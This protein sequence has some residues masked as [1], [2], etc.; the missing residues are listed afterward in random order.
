M[1]SSPVYGS[2]GHNWTLTFQALWDANNT[3]QPIGN[4]SVE[5]QV[6]DQKSQNIT[7]LSCNTTSGSFSFHYLSATPNVFTF[8]PI[9]LIT[10]DQTEW[11]I[12]TQGV[13]VWWDTFN[14]ELIDSET[15]N[16]GTATVFVNITHLLLP[17]GGLMANEGQGN[18]TFTAKIV[19][20]AN[21]AING[22]KAEE[23]T[24]SGIYSAD[25]STVLPG[26]YY[27]VNVSQSGWESAQVVFS[28]THDANVGAWFE[29]SFIGIVFVLLLSLVLFRFFKKEWPLKMSNRVGRF[30]FIGGVLL[31]CASLVSL[32]WGLIGVEGTLH[33]FDWTLL[34]ALELSCFVLGTVGSV[35]SVRKKNQGFVIFT[36]TVLLTGNFVAVKLSLE[37][38]GLPIDWLSVLASI[39]FCVVSGL[40]V[41]SADEEFAQIK[42]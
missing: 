9:K 17:E 5:I 2:I 16:F 8:T 39:V 22:I 19:H 6:T 37:T 14:V 15:N 4:A 23:T 7:K 1:T 18:Q 29:Y 24:T 38:Y 31:L 20:G 41:S 42:N 28:L 3:S 13:T 11:S 34:I 32:F 21:V 25:V 35:L 40:L 10:A 30:P 27:L 12:Q 36:S 26:A 33:G